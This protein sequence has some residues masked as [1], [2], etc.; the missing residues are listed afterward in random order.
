MFHSFF[1]HSSLDGYLN[2]SDSLSVMH[3]HIQAFFVVVTSVFCG[4]TS[5]TDGSYDNSM[6]TFSRN[7]QTVFHSDC[8][9]SH[10]CQ[11]CV[12]TLTSPHP[13]QHCIFF[14][15]DWF[16]LLAVQGTLKSLF[17]YH[18][19]KASVLQYS[20]FFMVHLSHPYM[21]TGKTIALTI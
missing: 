3:I 11:H 2:G 7:Y 8:A 19:S 17:Q 4:P 1:T 20:A 6:V 16:D 12:R 9:V 18:G 14:W 15:I 13:L 10:P 21:T 5:E